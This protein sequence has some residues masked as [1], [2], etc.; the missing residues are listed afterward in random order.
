MSLCLYNSLIDSIQSAG[1]ASIPQVLAG[2]VASKAREQ[3]QTQPDACY[4]RSSYPETHEDLHQSA[5]D[6]SLVVD[7]LRSI[8][9]SPGGFVQPDCWGSSG[10]A[11]L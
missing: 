7:A 5:G 6:P 3:W 10:A 11:S 2:T 4:V 9:A 1:G 8:L